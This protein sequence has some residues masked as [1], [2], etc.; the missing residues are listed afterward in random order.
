MGANFDTDLLRTFVAIA[1]SGSFTRAGEVVHRT[2]S[3]V[4]MQV[5]RLEDA[6]GK[7]VFEREGRSV[8][9]TPEGEALLGYARRILKLHEEAVATL[10]QPEMVG[11]V[12][13]GTP[14]DYVLRFLPGILKRFAQAYPRVQV[15]VHC[16][17]SASLI[18]L[19]E[20]R[21][22][23][24]AL[25]TCGPGQER[26]EVVRRDPVVWATSERHLVHE[27]EPLPLAL[28]QKGCFVREWVVKALD[29]AGRN[30]RIAYASP[31]ISG[32]HAAVT[33]GL[34]VTALA[35]S[36]LPPGVRRLSSEEGFP[37][38]PTATIALERAAHT[39][40]KAVDCLAAH[41]VEGFRSEG[42]EAA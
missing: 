11:T 3:A 31:S 14:D 1:D 5:K 16:D 30:Y 12:R 28:F 41:I 36:V 22:I 10:T 6:V 2:Q 27:E 29:E 39:R 21:E 25:I 7:P 24:L 4:S 38:L 26:G 23:D 15:A 20:T 8:A 33:A 19:L 40:S 17:P 32:I 35:S 9:L 42:A 13:V 34:A 18:G 37:Q